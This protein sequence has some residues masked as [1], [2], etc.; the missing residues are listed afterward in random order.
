MILNHLILEQWKFK[1]LCVD[2]KLLLLTP[3][4]LPLCSR[5]RRNHIDLVRHSRVPPLLRTT[6]IATLAFWHGF[7]VANN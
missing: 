6:V 1:P 2:K 5:R 3:H 4:R 7:K